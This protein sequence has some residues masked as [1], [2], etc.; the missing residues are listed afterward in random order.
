VPRD[1]LD[2]KDRGAKLVVIDPIFR[3]EAAKADWWIPI[4]PGGDAALFLGVCNH[5]LTRGLHNKEF[6]DKWVRPGDMDK[7]MSYIADKTPEAMSKICD[8]PAADI[9]KLAEMCAP[10]SLRMYRRL[11]VHHV[12]QCHGLGPRVEYVPRD[13]R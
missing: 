5:L 6:C 11:Q 13:N 8:V 9:V 10:S 7:L 3:T 12:R 4:K 2:A 1:I